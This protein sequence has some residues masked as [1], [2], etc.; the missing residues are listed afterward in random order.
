VSQTDIEEF[1]TRYGDA[2]GSGDPRAIAAHYATPALVVNDRATVDVLDHPG[3][4]AAFGAVAEVYAVKRLVAARPVIDNVDTL[5]ERLA[6]VAVT[7]EYLDTEGGSQPGESYRYL[8][9]LGDKPRIC[10]VIP[11]N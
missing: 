2:L 7:W 5:T 4:L 3:V 6:L 8:L 11:V 1:F 10:V 9:R